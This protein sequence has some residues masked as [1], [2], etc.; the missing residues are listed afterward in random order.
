MIQYSRQGLYIKRNKKQKLSMK[1]ESNIDFMNVFLFV[2]LII[3]II[4]FVVS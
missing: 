2:L 1:K 3:V 4:L